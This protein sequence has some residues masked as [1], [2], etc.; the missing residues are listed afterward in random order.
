MFAKRVGY[1]IGFLTITVLFAADS[2][3]KAD[4]GVNA[5]LNGLALMPQES[6]WRRDVTKDGVDPDSRK[7]LARIGL[8]KPLRPDFGTV[9]KGVPMGIPYVVV[10][11]DQPRVEVT[12]QYADE[13]DKVPY[14]IPPDPPIE[15]GPDSKGDRH[16]LMLDRDN[17]ML[18]ELFDAHPPKQA[19]KPWTAGSGAIFNLNKWKDRPDG[20]TSAD[21]AGLPILPG[22]VR[23][24]EVVEQKSLDHAI[25]FTLQKTRNK[26]V[27][28]ASHYASRLPDA[29]LL[30][31]GA[32]FRLRADFDEKPF[33]PAA[34]AILR[35]LKKHG[36]I[37]ADNGSDMFISGSP[38]EKWDDEVL[39]TL[40]RVKAKDF[41]VLRLG[42]LRP[43]R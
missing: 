31:M 16:I 14:P 41:E 7:Y 4:L 23:Y 15:G 27:A 36:M 17:W 3:K 38:H 28:P 20:W 5:S 2:H 30:P 8:D 43:V 39:A 22:L 42:E 10:G 35:G 26:Y 24:D 34:Q 37:L 11:K 1:T 18:Y 40:R 19:G 25:R 33:P 9:W 29:D 12:F 13:S 6:P 32:R 21:A